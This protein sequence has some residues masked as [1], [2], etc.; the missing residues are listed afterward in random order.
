MKDIIIYKYSIRRK[1]S[2]N[3]KDGIKS[4]VLSH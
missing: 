1:A 4:Q 3:V 2:I